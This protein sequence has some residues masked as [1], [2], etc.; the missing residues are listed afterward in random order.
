MCLAKTS[1]TLKMND[2]A[3]SWI[4]ICSDKIL[5][6]IVSLRHLLGWVVSTFRCRED[7]VLENLAPPTIASFARQTTSPSIERHALLK[8]VVVFIMRILAP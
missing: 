8:T 5:A 7:L 3:K 1:Y 4:Q 6:M 2:L